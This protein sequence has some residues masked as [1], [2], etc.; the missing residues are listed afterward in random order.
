MKSWTYGEIRKK[1]ELDLDLQYE[2]N[3]TAD[4]MVGYCNE[5]VTEAG[6]EI[7]KMNEWYFLAEGII[8]FVAETAAY[9]LP[10]DIFANKIR[11]VVY[12]NGSTIYPVRRVRG[13]AEN[14]Y[15]DI[16]EANTSGGS[17]DYR[18]YLLNNQIVFVP[19]ARESG[20]YIKMQ[21][22]KTPNYV[23][24]VSAGS[25]A[26]SDAIVINIPEFYSF[27]TQFMKVRC[28]E[29]DG[30]DPRLAQAATILE[31]ER[32]M[33]ISTLSQ[34]VVDDNDTLIPDTSFYEEHS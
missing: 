11:S 24:L 12:V 23:P 16:Q 2:T 8:T 5:A 25:Q 31:H 7:L 18:Y 20:A 27:V 3:I 22:L 14:M 30:A 26:A 9:N 6:S 19:T 28:L 29:K 21:Y 13:T 32:Q 33:M 1:I 34:M 17:A 15:V 4:E 10:S